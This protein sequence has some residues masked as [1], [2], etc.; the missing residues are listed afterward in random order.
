MRLISAS[1]RAALWVS[2]YFIALF[3]I[4]AILGPSLEAALGMIFV[5]EV[6]AFIS[7]PTRMVGPANFPARWQA[8][9]RVV[10]W[11]GLISSCWSL[12]VASVLGTAIMGFIIV[13]M[14]PQA[15]GQGNF[16]VA[17]VIAVWLLTRW[18]WVPPLDKQ[19]RRSLQGLNKE[20]SQYAPWVSVGPDGIYF[21]LRVK[22]IG[23]PQRRWVFHVTFDEIQEVRMLGAL[24]A[25]AY[26]ESMCQYDPTL[27]VRAGLE[28][29]SYFKGDLARPSIFESLSAGTHI[30]VRSPTVLYLM[31]EA[32]GTAPA[33]VVAWQGW[34][35]AR[36]APN[37]PTD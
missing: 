37:A 22:T 11:Y 32:D 8:P 9:V 4:A 7:R 29:F 24:D 35:A 17:G 12:A 30:L 5:A 34:R 26:W 2:Y 33:A 28:M 21:E 14:R 31:G 15:L 13:A 36:E 19:L 20:T 25:Q 18:L 10:M 27:A 1:L 3:M 6:L 16:V 23:G